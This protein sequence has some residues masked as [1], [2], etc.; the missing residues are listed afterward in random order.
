MVCVVTGGR[1]RIGYQIVLKLLRAGAF[2]L[3]TTRYPADAVQR[4]AR[5][6]DFGD[7]C[8]R[9]E[10]MGPVELSDIRLVERFCDDLLARF[11]RIHVLINNAAQV[12]SYHNGFLFVGLYNVSSSLIHPSNMSRPSPHVHLISIPPLTQTTDK[13]SPK[14]TGC[15]TPDAA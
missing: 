13:P 9:L 10:I 1:V 15:P 7:W 6:P 2:V 11:P 12:C 5:E 3:T 14:N 4:Y 8:D